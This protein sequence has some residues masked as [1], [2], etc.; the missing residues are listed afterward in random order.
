MKELLN[1][2]SKNYMCKIS[3]YIEENNEN[4]FLKLLKQLHS[5]LVFK[6]Y[7]SPET[8][9]YYMQL[10]IQND[11]IGHVYINEKNNKFMIRDYD[12]P[13]NR[14]LLYTILKRHNL[15]DEELSCNLQRII[16]EDI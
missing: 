15:L 13:R 7:D 4:S 1:I 5:K 14:L 11:L 10:W 6:I 2:V 9:G 12:N 16:L 8:K 3:V